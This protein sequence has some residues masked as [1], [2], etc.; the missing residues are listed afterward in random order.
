M[1]TLLSCP[2]A[3]DFFQSETP[4]STP[5]LMRGAGAGAEST[6]RWATAEAETATLE[7]ARK[8]RRLS[9]KQC[10]PVYPR[11]AQPLASTGSAGGDSRAEGA[12]AWGGGFCS[13]SA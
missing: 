1:D 13:D 12:A 11:S 4:P 10:S 6:P 2:S 9:L 8:R 7:E 3:S 5:A